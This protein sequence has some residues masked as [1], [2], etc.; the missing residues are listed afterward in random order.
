MTAVRRIA[1]LNRERLITSAVIIGFCTAISGCG[2]YTEAPGLS[3]EQKHMQRAGQL[4]IRASMA[5]NNGVTPASMEELK[6]FA[7]KLSADALKEIGV[8]DV[9]KA[10]MSPRDG[11]PLVLIGGINIRNVM[12][13]GQPAD[14]KP[15]QS[16]SGKPAGGGGSPPII[17]YEKTG[18]GGMHYVV[19]SIS[20]GVSEVNEET[21]KERVPSYKP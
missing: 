4:V 18:R 2:S 5:G 6:T 12:A 7:K 1:S 14:Q 3:D 13:P 11:S 8:D 21:L 16:K 15:G 20:A 9:D 17:L 19:Y 10:M